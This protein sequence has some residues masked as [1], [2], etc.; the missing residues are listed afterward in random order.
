MSSTEMSMNPFLKIL[1]DVVHEKSVYIKTQQPRLESLLEEYWRG[2]SFKVPQIQSISLEKDDFV[3]NLQYRSQTIRKL[4]HAMEDGY[5]VVKAIVDYFFL[6]YIGK[7]EIK[8]DFPPKES[9]NAQYRIVEDLLGSLLQFVVLDKTPIPLEYVIVAK[10]KSLLKIK[11]LPIQ[12]M[13]D[14]LEKDNIALSPEDVEK[15]LKNLVNLG[16]VEEV[17]DPKSNQTAFRFVG[18]FTLN[19]ESEKI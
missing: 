19:P 4:Q 7:Q 16:F 9:I 14:G 8:Q 6:D 2:V 1:W 18:D 13:V 3:N 12:R 10:F 15:S 11:A 5:R 17:E